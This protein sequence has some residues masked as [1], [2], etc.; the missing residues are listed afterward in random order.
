MENNENN[1]EQRIAKLEA[2][3]A[4]YERLLVI[5][6]TQLVVK[7]SMLVNGM[8]NGDRI[9]TKRTGNHVELVT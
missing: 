7:Q 2:K 1:L 4:M 6:P 5:T 8:V 3:L 9:F